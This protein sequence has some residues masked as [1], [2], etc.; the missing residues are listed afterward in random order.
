M[1]CYFFRK[2]SYFNF[3]CIVVIEVYFGF[4]KELDYKLLVMDEVEI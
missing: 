3:E 2:I 4:V 1:K